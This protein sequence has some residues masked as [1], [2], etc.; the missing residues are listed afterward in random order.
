MTKT[1]RGSPTGQKVNE[2]L[3]DKEYDLPKS[4]ADIFVKEMKVAKVVTEKMKKEAEA[5]KAE[6][7]K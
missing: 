6:E 4:L 3:K 7:A 5:K 2:Y 1:E